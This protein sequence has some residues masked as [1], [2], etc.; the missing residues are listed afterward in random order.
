VQD[1]SEAQAWHTFLGGEGDVLLSTEAEAIRAR[2]AGAK[3]DLIVPNQTLLVEVPVAVTTSS[4]HPQQARAFLRWLWTSEAQSLLPAQGLRPVVASGAPQTAF[5]HP[6]GLFTI[7]RVGGWRS[8]EHRFFDAS[9]GWVTH[10]EQ[11]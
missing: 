7:R 2:R 6:T 8:A 9:S 4:A 1:P 10:I 5:P 3:I 11:E